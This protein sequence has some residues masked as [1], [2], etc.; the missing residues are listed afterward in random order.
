[1]ADV[2]INATTFT[3]GANNYGWTTSTGDNISTIFVGG[4]SSI[5]PHPSTYSPTYPGVDTVIV[6][7]ISALQVDLWPLDSVPM[8]VSV[9]CRTWV[10][11]EAYS[12]NEGLLGGLRL[13]IGAEISVNGP[14]LIGGMPPKIDRT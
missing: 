5:V 1:M 3:S 10:A 12:P 7:S 9:E 2:V 8:D 13:C 4:I 6:P 14:Y 11:T